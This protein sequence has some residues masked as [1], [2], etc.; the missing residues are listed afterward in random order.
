MDMLIT[1]ELDSS[2]L[3]QQAKENLAIFAQALTDERL[4]R[5][6]FVVEGHTDGRGNEV[7]NLGL[8]KSRAASVKEYL[9]ELGVPIERLTAIGLGENEPRTGDVLDPENRRVELRIDLQ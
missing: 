6:R 1:F 7:Y 3:T 4:S 8:S 5:A 2:E 9:T